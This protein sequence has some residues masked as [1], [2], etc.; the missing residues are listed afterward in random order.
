MG[1][2]GGPAGSFYIYQDLPPAT[3]TNFAGERESLRVSLRWRPNTEADVSH[4]AIYRGSKLP[5]THSP[6]NMIAR[7]TFDYSSILDWSGIDT[8]FVDYVDSSISA[9]SDYH[10]VIIAVDSNLLASLPSSPLSFIGTDVEDGEDSPLPQSIEL[11]QNYPNPFNATTAI[12]YSLPNIGAQPAAVKLVIFNSLGQQVRV[13][14]DQ[15]QLPGRQEA[16]WDGND[17]GGN[18]VASGVYFYS[19]KVSGVELIKSRK[20]VVVK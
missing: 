4:Y 2:L 13:L 5:I 8:I 14:V 12:V 20:M 10:Y 15:V 9:G 1:A 16:Y 19:L 3:P 7:V 6:E 17:D 11:E 18:A